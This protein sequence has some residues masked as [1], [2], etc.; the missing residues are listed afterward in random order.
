MK[1]TLIIIIIFITQSGFGQSYFDNIVD[2]TC[3]CLSKID[4]T[5]DKEQINAAGDL[6]IVD[7]CKPYRKELKKDYGLDMD[8]FD[9]TNDKFSEALGIKMS[10]KCPI[11]LF[12]FVAATS[13]QDESAK[14]EVVIE[15]GTITS[16]EKDAFIYFNLKNEAGKPS[17]LYWLDF[18]QSDLD[19]ISNYLT[20]V[21]KKVEM[22]YVN[23]E[24]FDPKSSEYRSFKVIKKI[25]VL[26]S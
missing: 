13:S 20:L 4:S 3:S 18:I 10:T 25:V 2:N 22:S 11:V 15:I 19:I 16:S 1:K 14:E 21:G 17:K 23:K 9:E 6:C 5:L 8:N 12:R 24:L 7:E 26:K